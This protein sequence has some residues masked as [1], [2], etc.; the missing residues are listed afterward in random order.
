M[1]VSLPREVHL[2]VVGGAAG[3]VSGAWTRWVGLLGEGRVCG[4][5]LRDAV[6]GRGCWTVCVER[7]D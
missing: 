7:S 5:V 3:E 2:G 6:M 4:C 1:P